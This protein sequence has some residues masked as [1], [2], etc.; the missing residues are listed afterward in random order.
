MSVLVRDN[1]LLCMGKGGHRYGLPKKPVR[2]RSKDQ[3]VETALDPDPSSTAS[4][5]PLIREAQTDCP[6]SKAL[7]VMVATETSAA[8]RPVPM[9]TSPN[10]DV[11]LVGSN[12]YHLPARNASM[13]P[14][15]SGGCRS[16]AY[17]ATY[18][19][20]MPMPRQSVIAR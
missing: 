16:T 9:R 5:L 12:R 13:N 8:S 14:W 3:A 17:P 7:P 11:N 6:V 1:P 4:V 15:K 20:G 2:N 10:T 18:R 19:A